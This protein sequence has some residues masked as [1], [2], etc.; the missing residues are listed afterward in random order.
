MLSLRSRIASSHEDI[1][2]FASYADKSHPIETNTFL[3]IASLPFGLGTLLRLLGS[4][5]ASVTLNAAASH[6]IIKH[7]VAIPPGAV[8][9]FSNRQSKTAGTTTGSAA[10][11]IHPVIKMQSYAILSSEPGILK[12]ATN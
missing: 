7:P 4:L 9:L 2:K 3:S 10:I 11:L 8:G 12:V 5:A 1:S 6:G